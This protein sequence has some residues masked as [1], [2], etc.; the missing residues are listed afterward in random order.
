VAVGRTA[1]REPDDDVTDAD[2]VGYPQL[3]I[4]MAAV[5]DLAF[6]GAVAVHVAFY[7]VVGWT[8]VLV[9]VSALV[10]VAATITALAAK[11][12]RVVV[13]AVVLVACAGLGAIGAAVDGGLRYRDLRQPGHNAD[14]VNDRRLGGAMLSSASASL[15]AIVALPLAGYLAYGVFR[16]DRVS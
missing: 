15:A 2:H 10:F 9:V 16:A 12:K 13:G 3:A 8:V 14:G 11:R 7:D 1:T 6:T 5:A 4:L